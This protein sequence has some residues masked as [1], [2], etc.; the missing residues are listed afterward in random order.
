M[1]IKNPEVYSLIESLGHH[2]RNNISNRFTRGALMLL[3]L[4]N[5]TWNQIEELTEKTDNYKYQGYHIEELY[6][7]IMAMGKFISVAR[8]QTSQSL[9]YVGNDRM[10]P[11]DRVLKDMVVNNFASNMNILADSLNKLFIKI[12]EIDKAQASG[13]APVYTKFPELQ[14]LGRY[15]VG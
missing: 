3:N 15:L 11:Q 14:D 7:L 13:R 8:K 1:Q 4:D 10:S 9:R 6:A 5:A 2:Y 12:V